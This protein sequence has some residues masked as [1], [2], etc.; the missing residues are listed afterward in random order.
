MQSARTNWFQLFGDTIDL[1]VLLGK[2]LGFGLLM[3]AFILFPILMVML[4]A[5]VLIKR[6]LNWLCDYCKANRERHS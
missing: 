3:A 4:S 5:E 1:V 6:P 2:G